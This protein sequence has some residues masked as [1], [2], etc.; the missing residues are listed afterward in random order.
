[1]S[2]RNEIVLNANFQVTIPLQRDSKKNK[3]TN[4]KEWRK[5]NRTGKQ[6]VCNKKY[7]IPKTMHNTNQFL[8]EKE[9]TV[10]EDQKFGSMIGIF[11][12][13]KM[14]SFNRFNKSGES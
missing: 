7:L 4:R 2:N 9:K 8:A 3:K 11:R 14:D 10:V 1:M 13:F 12:F 6:W 5:K